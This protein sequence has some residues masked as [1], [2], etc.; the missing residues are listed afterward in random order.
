HG[1]PSRPLLT[2]LLLT[3]LLLSLSSRLPL[4]LLQ[5]LRAEPYLH[6][7]LDEENA[8]PVRCLLIP[9]ESRRLLALYEL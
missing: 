9:A 5:K 1:L 7:P 4:R 3:D 2:S 8:L 6:N